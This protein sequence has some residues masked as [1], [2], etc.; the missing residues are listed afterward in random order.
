MLTKYLL[1]Q[2]GHRASGI[3]FNFANPVYACKKKLE[4]FEG[5][6]Q[7]WKQ[8]LRFPKVTVLYSLIPNAGFGLY[9]TEDVKAGQPIAT[10]QREIISRH[11]KEAREEGIEFTLSKCHFVF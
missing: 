1:V 6:P 10:Y 8:V 3:H 4:Q 2:V 7:K 5:Q 11:G 9:V